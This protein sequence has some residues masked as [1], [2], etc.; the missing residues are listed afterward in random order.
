MDR[1]LAMQ[2][3]CAV[4]DAGAFARAAE[5]LNLST[6][7][8]SRHVAELERH[9]GAR[10]LQRSTR[11]LSL[12]ETG[13]AYYERCRQILADV[14]EA[15][16][17]AGAAEARPHGLLRV[18]L[19]HSF[20]LAYVAPLLPEFCA[21]YPELELEVGFSDRV[22]DLVAEGVD[23]ALRIGI[24]LRTTLVARRLATIRIVPCAAPGYLARRGTPATPEE[25]KAH[26]CLTYAYA[27]F[28][29]VW[30]FQ[31]DGLEHAVAV[32]GSFRADSGEM[33]R[34]MTLAGRGVS[35]QPTFIM[36]EDLRAGRLARL[37]P[38][39]RVPDRHLYAVYLGGARRS[40]RVRAF[41]SHFETAFGG[42]PPP[43]DRGL[44]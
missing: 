34:T 23:L 6:S 39:Y 28:G 21:R 13:A 10:L 32:K 5:R 12:T 35:L 33:L 36:G 8:V 1:L 16:S 37:L 22:V 43:W 18:S 40:A 24:D 2:V 31:R 7:A 9:L 3:Y 11:R 15:E 30:K 41:V 42:D 20:G 17:L 26:D 38:D 27:A 25:L 29:D 14:D 19:P 44:A 4:V